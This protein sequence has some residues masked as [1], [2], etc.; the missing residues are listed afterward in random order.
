MYIHCQMLPMVFKS[1]KKGGSS[2]SSPG[3][4]YGRHAGAAVLRRFLA[5]SVPTTCF[6]GQGVG[7]GRFYII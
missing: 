3:V 5:P 6:A 4:P 7:R 2:G 1:K